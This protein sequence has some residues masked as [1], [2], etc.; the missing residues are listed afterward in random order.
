MNYIFRHHYICN[1]ANKYPSIFGLRREI[2]EAPFK[3]YKVLPMFCYSFAVTN[4]IMGKSEVSQ[5]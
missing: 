2:N 3:Q 4:E 1:I 5:F